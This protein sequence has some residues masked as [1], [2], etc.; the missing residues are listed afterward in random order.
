MTS[1]DELYTGIL[2]NYC[3]QDIS[4]IPHITLGVFVT[5]SS[6]YSQALIE[7]N[8]LKLDY[9]CVMDKLHLVKINADKSQISLTKEFSIKKSANQIP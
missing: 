8:Q 5:K 9:R 2:A 1:D 7:A 4:Y 6:E 3:R